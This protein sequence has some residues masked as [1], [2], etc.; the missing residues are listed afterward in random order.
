MQGTPPCEGRQPGAGGRQTHRR[1]GRPS[2]NGT[3]SHRLGGAG[4]GSS[5]PCCVRIGGRPVSSFEVFTHCGPGMAGER[6]QTGGV[7]PEVD[8]SVCAMRGRLCGRPC[9]WPSRRRD[10][11]SC[12]V[13]SFQGRYTRQLSKGLRR[14]RQKGLKETPPGRRVDRLGGWVQVPGW[15]AS[16]PPTLRPR[17]AS[18][19]LRIQR[20]SF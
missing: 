5:S 16:F 7:V 6:A 8:R 14:G 4:R 10:V 13:S 9:T 1:A 15:L 11:C 19:P 2:E 3:A 20:C 17:T 18:W 12:R